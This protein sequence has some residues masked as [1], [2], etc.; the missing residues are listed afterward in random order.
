MTD[1]VAR[2]QN[3]Q[4]LLEDPLFQEAFE[5]LEKNTIAILMASDGPRAS[6]AEWLAVLRL[7]PRIKGW[8]IQQAQ[9]GK[10][11]LYEREQKERKNG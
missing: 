4:R 1:P 5:A 2:A 3:A 8:F 6:D 9:T 7:L 10:V 11:E